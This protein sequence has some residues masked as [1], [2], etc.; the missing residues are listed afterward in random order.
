MPYAGF[1]V[2]RPEG[3]DVYWY[4]FSPSDGLLAFGLRGKA[5]ASSFFLEGR[6]GFAA[7]GMQ[8]TA[9]V[10]RTP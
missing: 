1:L 9:R 3:D 10:G 8:C 4:L 5:V 7:A 2:E 6:C